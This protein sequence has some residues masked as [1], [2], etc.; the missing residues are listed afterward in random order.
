MTRQSLHIITLLTSISIA[1]PFLLQAKDLG[2][3]GRVYE[4]Q[5]NDLLSVLQSRAQAELDS[6]KWAKRVEEWQGQAKQQANRP[7][8]IILPRA[9]ETTSHLY[10]PSIIVPKDIKDTNGL[11]IRAAGSQINPLSYISMTRNLVFIDGD[12][13]AQ[14]DWMVQLTGSEPGR[15]KIILTQGSVIDLMKELNRQLFFDQKQVYTQKMNIKSLP[16]LV[17]QSGLHLRIDEVAIQ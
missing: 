6:G 3:H 15:Y 5:E 14:V 10:D 17:Y 11:L 2:V 1:F 8:G 12:D 16:A 4:I 13:R 9:T 7:N